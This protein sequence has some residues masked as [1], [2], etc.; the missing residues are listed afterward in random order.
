MNFTMSMNIIYICRFCAL[1]NNQ[2]NIIASFDD[3]FHLISDFNGNK[4][5]VYSKNQLLYKPMCQLVEK[6]KIRN[7]N[8]C[9][10]DIPIYI[11]NA[12]NISVPMFLSNNNFIKSFSKEIQCSLVNDKTILPSINSTI[13]RIGNSIKVL[14][15]TNVIVKQIHI[16]HTIYQH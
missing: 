14:N 8:S 6:I 10:S 7:S 11:K 9:H 16:D 12:E 4:L 1:F 2:L 3:R 15:L 5:I 13:V